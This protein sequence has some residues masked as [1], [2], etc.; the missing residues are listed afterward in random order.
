MAV[1]IIGRAFGW[2]G[3]R[4]LLY[5]L[6]V[7]AIG[8]ATFALPW[9]KREV[10]GDRQAQ[11]RYAALNL[12]RERLD[13]EADAAGR[14]AASSI[15]A[16]R[17]Q[18][19]AALDARIVAAE[20]EKGALE[21]AG[22][23][24]PSTFKLALQ[25][26]DALI[27][28]KRR[29]LRILMLD[30][31]IG[32]LRA[33]RALAAADQA[34]IAAAID[35]RRQHAVAVEAIR[36]CDTA[37][38]ALATFERR[39]RW[40]FRS[41]LDNDEHRALTARM[42]AACSE[43]RQAV[44]RHNLL[45]RTGREAA[46]AR[47]QANVALAKAQAAGAAQLDAWRQTFAADVQRART[48][49][50]GN[51]SERVRLWMERLGIT[52]IL[53][54]AAWALLAIIL[55][56]YAIRLLF[57][58]M[59]APMAERRAAIRLRVP[60]GSGGIIALPGPST[61][62][63]AIRLERGEELLVRQ[64]YLQSTSHGGAKATRWLLDY[65]HPLSSLVSGLSFLTRIRGDG[66]MTTISAVRDPF[67]ETVILVLPEGSACVLQPRA[68]AAVAQPIGR[69]LRISSH[70][71]LFSLNA[72]LTLQLRYLVFH[73]PARL[74][75]KG[76]RGVRVERAEHGRVFGQDQLV[77]FSADLAYSVTRT[78]TFWPYFLGREPLFKDR[79]EAGDG[80]LI[81]EEA[82]LA[83]RKGEPRHGLEGT[84]DAALKLV[85]L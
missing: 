56:P 29:E 32:G 36:S 41:W 79:V 50:S 21:Q 23:N 4:L 48:E 19:M 6:L 58:H 16:T 34:S 66:E 74:V 35:T 78:E 22:R 28:A 31:E 44:A 83:G 63:V 15:A 47:E 8:F 18:G 20:A 1:K 11:Q 13:A 2:L 64:D 84:L 43:A 70:W 9:I 33:T 72:W 42:T 27:A 68:L 75:L 55:T 3:R 69:P 5:G 76:G 65:R 46:A 73:G 10:A 53:V 26:S 51:W 37:R 39:W 77:G 49:W 12:S 85:G 24:A 30:R 62:S 17:R 82:P 81:V 25:G 60:G 52:S 45:V 7:A 38:E 57:F 14:R 59:L 61:T 67:A 80:L 40:R 54:A 71:R